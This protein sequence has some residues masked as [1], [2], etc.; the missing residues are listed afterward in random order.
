MPLRERR[1]S[2]AHFTADV[3]PHSKSSP[4]VFGGPCFL[5]IRIYN[6]RVDK[7]PKKE[8]RNISE[9][10][11]SLDLAEQLDWATALIWEDK[12]KDYGER[13]YCVLGF[14]EDRLHSVVFTPRDG[15]PPVIS[16]RKANKREVK[17]Y[18]KATQI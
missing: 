12:R 9:R 1:R 3:G 11:L 14:I 15:K 7:D 17:R 10:G 4:Q 8:G 2:H 5:Y 16:L 6:G 13:R 18:E